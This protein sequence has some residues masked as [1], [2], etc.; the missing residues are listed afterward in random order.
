MTDTLAQALR[1]R[2]SNVEWH[3]VQAAAIAWAV[4]SE[5]PYGNV[6]EAVTLWL[7]DLARRNLG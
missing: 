1:N 4:S 6:D 7:V 2:L 3:R 5:V